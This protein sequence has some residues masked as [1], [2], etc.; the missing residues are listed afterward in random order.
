[1]PPR[2]VSKASRYIRGTAQGFGACALAVIGLVML[3]RGSWGGVVVIV[4]A[5]AI[6]IAAMTNFWLAERASKSDRTARQAV[7]KG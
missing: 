1:M 7:T 5:V 6:A 2:S 3:T 4:I